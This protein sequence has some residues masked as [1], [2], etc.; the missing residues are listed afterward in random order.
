MYSPDEEEHEH[1][2]E[3]ES[4]QPVEEIELPPA[5]LETAEDAGPT[6]EA[7]TSP[8]TAIEL[9]SGAA[10]QEGV[11]EEPKTPKQ[12]LFAFLKNFR[13]RLEWRKQNPGG[14]LT[15]K[16]RI[17]QD[18]TRIIAAIAGASILAIVIFLVTFTRPATIH[19]VR[20]Q[21]AHPNLGR[22]ENSETT[23][24]RS[25]VPLRSA[26]GVKPED[27]DG[28]LSDQDILN[29]SAQSPDPGWHRS[30]LC[31]TPAMSETPFRHSLFRQ[32]TRQS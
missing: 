23:D 31:A 25:G 9:E 10:T 1:P 29:T 22:P 3:H 19:K 21:R 24:G 30:C 32:P 20:D 16:S 5:F 26:A 6:P 11:I 17:T 14:T 28:R 13:E 12:R 15:A 8:T 2:K 27:R 7:G 18:R 4:G